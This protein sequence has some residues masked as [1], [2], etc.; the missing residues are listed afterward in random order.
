MFNTFTNM[1]FLEGQS[2]EC[3]WTLIPAL[4]L[5]QIAA[6]SLRL[7]YMLDECSK[8]QVTLKT[9]AHQWYWS[10]EYSDV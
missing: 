5:I 1:T 4:V 7:L 8:A 9:I 3:A 10:Y 6:P 2:I